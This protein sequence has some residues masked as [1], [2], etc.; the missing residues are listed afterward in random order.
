[1]HLLAQL[2]SI[3]HGTIDSFAAGGHGRPLMAYLDPGSGSYLLQLLIAGI[4]GGALLLRAYWARVGG[5]F[6][7][8]LRRNDHSHDE[9]LTSADSNAASSGDNDSVK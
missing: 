1:M 2:G 3:M 7:R 5:F 6:R 9:Q 8:L 4:V